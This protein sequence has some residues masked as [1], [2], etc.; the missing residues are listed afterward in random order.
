MSLIMLRDRSNRI[1]FDSRCNCAGNACNR[2]REAS[3]IR[4]DAGGGAT[5]TVDDVDDDDEST[6]DGNAVNAG[7]SAMNRSTIDGGNDTNA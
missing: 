3:I 4:I 5:T 7:L 2:H 6:G 1:R